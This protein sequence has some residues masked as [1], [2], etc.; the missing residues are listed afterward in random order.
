M[1]PIF[2]IS[3]C[4]RQKAPFLRSERTESFLFV[5]DMKGEVISCSH[6]DIYFL[7][8]NTK[9][10]VS[11]IRLIVFL[12]NSPIVGNVPAGNSHVCCRARGDTFNPLFV[13]IVASAANSIAEWIKPCGTAA[14]IV[15]E[16]SDNSNIVRAPAIA[17]HVWIY[18]WGKKLHKNSLVKP[19]LYIR[20]YNF[21]IV[22]LE[23]RSFA[24]WKVFD[25]R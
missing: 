5:A 1:I 19:L 10:E 7:E 14:A 18:S 16:K 15:R 9:S 4:I 22:Y 20:N 11:Y 6:K 21:G 12:F 25:E 24:F 8:T 17:C 3:C 2:V 13:C 23:G